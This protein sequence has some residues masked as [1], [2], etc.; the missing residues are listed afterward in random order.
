MDTRPALFLLPNQF[1]RFFEGGAHACNRS[2]EAHRAVKA[3]SAKA[4]V[5]SAYEMAPAYPKTDSDGD[6]AAAARYHAMNNVFFL[7]AVMKGR[8]PRAFVGEPPYDAMGFKA[9]DEKL[10]H[11]PLDWS[12][13]TTTRAAS[14]PTRARRSLRA[15]AIS[16]APRSKTIHRADAIRTRAS[17]PRCLW[18]GH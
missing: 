12:A 14:S 10:L 3:A 2:G 5:G 16:A 15:E 7:E 1:R 8:Y 18:R 4:T 17:V 9:G 11:A 6:R 13:F